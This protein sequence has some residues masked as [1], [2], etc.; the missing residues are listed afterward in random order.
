LKEAQGD[1][2]LLVFSYDSIALA[3]AECVVSEQQGSVE[4]R[5]RALADRFLVERLKRATTPE[6]RLVVLDSLVPDL[7]LNI[8]LRR[9]GP[10]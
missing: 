4:E 9:G 6:E 8:C 10:S 2:R 7:V 1:K 5:C 3:Q